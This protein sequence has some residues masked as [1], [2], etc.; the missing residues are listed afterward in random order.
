[1]GGKNLKTKRQPDNQVTPPPESRGSWTP[2]PDEDCYDNCPVD[3]SIDGAPGGLIVTMAQKMD[4]KTHEMVF[5]AVTLKISEGDISRIDTAHSTV[6]RH[7]FFRNSGRQEKLRT[8]RPLHS[9]NDVDETYDESISH[10]VDNGE[11]Y[12]WRW[13]Y[14][15]ESDA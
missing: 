11:K 10:L 13:L 1:M 9:R 8:I 3:W 6:H 15:D 2:P 12:H 5:Y 7:Q 14:G 4:A